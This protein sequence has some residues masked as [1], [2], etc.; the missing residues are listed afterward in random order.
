[1]RLLRAS[2]YTAETAWGSDLLERFDGQTT[3]KLHWTDQP[4]VWHVN[5]GPEVLAVMDGRIE[6]HVR[7]DGVVRVIPM[8]T[9]DVMHFEDGDEHVAHPVGEARLL[10]IERAETV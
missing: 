7:K 9:G 3:V 10:V 8:Q 1:M 6:M 4:Y 2:D 5:D